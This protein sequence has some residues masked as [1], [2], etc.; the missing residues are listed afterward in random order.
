MIAVFGESPYPRTQIWSSLPLKCQPSTAPVIGFALMFMLTAYMTRGLQLLTGSHKKAQ[1]ARAEELGTPEDEIP[2]A[3]RAEPGPTSSLPP[4][5]DAS[6]R[7]S[8]VA[9][10]DL[11]IPEES[12]EPSRTQQVADHPNGSSSPVRAHTNPSPSPLPRQTPPVPPRARLWAAIIQANVDIV[13]YLVLLLF[14]GIPVYYAT[15]YAM[16]LQLTTTVLMYF[17]A[18]SLPLKWKQILHPV[19]VSAFLTVLAVWVLGLLRGEGLNP[20][21]QEYSTGLKYLQLWERTAHASSTLRPGAGDV[22]GTVLDASIVSL[23]LPMYQYRRELVAHFAAIIVPNIVLAIGSLY[24]YPTICF[25]LGISAPRSLAFASRSL[26]LALAIPA[27]ENL[28]GDR[29]TVA[30]VAI[31][32]GIVGALIGGRV[33]TWLRIP[34]G[35]LGVS[36]F[37]TGVLLFTHTTCSI[38][39]FSAS[40]VLPHQL[41]SS[42]WLLH[43]HRH[44][45]S[46]DGPPVPRSLPQNTR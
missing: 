6:A 37:M 46:S 24:A 40:P 17:A 36:P 31:M 41:V 26:T 7:T 35:E 42:R 11:N 1:A 25:A 22:L 20:V 33:L 16:P 18:L 44:K 10:Q 19:I 27:T 2:M 21:L 4:S 5:A 38:S 12:H 9:L 15:G 8:A 39:R 13:I 23:A 14:V 29:N 30:A 43:L 45:M 3:Q 32:S 34:E 28:G